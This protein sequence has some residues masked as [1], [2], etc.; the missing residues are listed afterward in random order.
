MEI[1]YKGI[2]VSLLICFQ[3][4]SGIE[5]SYLSWQNGGVPAG[6]M[7]AQITVTREAPM[8]RIIPTTIIQDAPVPTGLYENKN[9]C[10]CPFRL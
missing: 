8:T 5:S 1:K 3:L 7:N 2:L 6:Y 9:N 4:F 10:Y